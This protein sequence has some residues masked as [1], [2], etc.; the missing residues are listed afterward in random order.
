[1][2]EVSTFIPDSRE[3]DWKGFSYDFF[4]NCKSACQRAQEPQREPQTAAD[5]PVRVWELKFFLMY[6]KFNCCSMKTNTF[7]KGSVLETAR[8]WTPEREI[9][10]QS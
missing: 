7:Y 5:A 4:F 1:M 3:V 8:C 10:L 9:C 2:T 6:S